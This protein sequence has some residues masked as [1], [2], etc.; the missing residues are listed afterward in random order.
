MAQ[1]NSWKNTFIA[2]R[3]IFFS[4]LFLFFGLLLLYSA[5]N[6]FLKTDISRKEAKQTQEKI[7]ELES[8]KSDLSQKLES[9]ES[10]SGQEKWL[11]QV[12]N[13]GKEGEQVIIIVDDD[14]ISQ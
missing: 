10:H 7:R 9:L 5:Y 14:T 8:R 3:S 2:V 12:Y 11:R 4:A 6:M 1:F 13:A